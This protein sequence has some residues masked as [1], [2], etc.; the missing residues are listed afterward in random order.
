MNFPRFRF[1]RRS[2]PAAPRP[3]FE[4]LE[5]R[6][7]LST[8]PSPTGMVITG[9]IHAATSI[10][11]AFNEPL[12]PTTAQDT[13]AYSFGR[14]PPSG[15]SSSSLGD[16]LGFLA[17][18][19]KVI[20]AGKVQ[21]S[22][23]V[24][25][26][27]NNTVTLTAVA[28]FNAQ[29]Y[30]RILRVRGTGHDVVTDPQGDALNGGKDTVIRWSTHFGKAVRYTDADGDR[31]VLQLKG[32]GKLYGFERRTGD[33]DPILFVTGTNSKSVLT[34]TIRQGRLGNGVT[35]I[36]EILGAETV[37]TNLFAS[38]QFVIGAVEP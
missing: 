24:Y 32:P 8:A 13:A 36:A 21:F 5:S 12:D 23:A 38:P 20:K 15:S 33:P 35:D 14:I 27:T 9:T 18:R 17:K 16:I 22:S 4:P 30:F 6:R 19:P 31:V 25:D 7:M 29:E 28:P 37:Q 10:V 3:A 1:G 34:G 26:D 11:I 2:L